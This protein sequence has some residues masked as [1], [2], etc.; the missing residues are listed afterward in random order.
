MFY[1]L[2]VLVTIKCDLESSVKQLNEINSGIAFLYTPRLVYLPPHK[3]Q[4][5]NAMQ[6]TWHNVKYK[7][8]CENFKKDLRK[9]EA[10]EEIK[11]NNNNNNGENLVGYVKKKMQYL[12]A[13]SCLKKKIVYQSNI[14]LEK[15]QKSTSSTFINKFTLIIINAAVRNNWIGDTW[16][17]A[18]FTS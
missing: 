4:N 13:T 11:N 5:T 12:L 15:C 18:S 16:L 14:L 10:W 8:F 7:K 2:L 6:T 1:F 3:D 17:Y 9:H